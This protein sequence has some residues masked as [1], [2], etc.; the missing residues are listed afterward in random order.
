MGVSSVLFNPDLLDGEVSFVTGAS[1]GLGRDI[2]KILSDAGAAVA[3]GARRMDLLRDLAEEIKASGGR[4][5][6]VCLDVRD[7]E[8]TRNAVAEAEQALGP[9]TVLVN[10][11]GMSI[12]KSFLDHDE[13][14]Y[15]TVVDTVLKGV[16]LMTQAVARR[17]VALGQGGRIVNIGSIYGQRTALNA[18][19]YCAAKGGVLHLTKVLAVELAGY[20][21]R[22]NALSP[23][24]FHTEMTHDI[25]ERGFADKMI[26]RTPL[27]RSGVRDDLIAPLL[28]LASEGSQFMT[29][30]VIAVDGGVLQNPM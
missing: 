20:G 23:G 21:I 30:E 15:D 5:Y 14:D 13:H 17:L 1:S 24:L 9:I 19:S 27:K 29:G 25:F 22:V 7:A 10:N 28:L 12:N 26:K 8:S 16:W 18:S 3:V 4:A 11:A 6:P 2:A